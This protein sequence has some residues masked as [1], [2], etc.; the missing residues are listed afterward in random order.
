M[1]VFVYYNLHRRVWSIKA[2]SGSNRGRVVAHAANVV[3]S[4]VTCRVSEAGR[5]RVIRERRKNVHAG[6]VGEL[7]SCGDLPWAVRDDAPAITYNPYI[8]P[9]FF[10]KDNGAPVTKARIAVMHAG[11][12]VRVNALLE[13]A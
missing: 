8:A 2:L 12:K 9:T 6:L 3:L 4:D 11:E 1:R 10:R 13:A 5:Q 7:V